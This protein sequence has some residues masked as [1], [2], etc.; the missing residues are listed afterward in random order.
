MKQRE[1]AE[2]FLKKAS[3]DEKLLKEVINSDQIVDDI[4]GFHCQQAAE[5]LFKALLSFKGIRFRK[6]HD[7][8]ELMDLLED[9]KNSVPE[10]L[11]DIDRLT[12]FGTLFRYD[13]LDESV[14]FDREEA[15]KMVSE[16]R[17]WVEDQ[18]KMSKE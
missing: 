13:L 15:M 3:Q 17:K 1:Q 4:F 14:G 8:R 7:L 2:L 10:H 12:P 5:K 18:I 16:L 6:T 9:H 11:A